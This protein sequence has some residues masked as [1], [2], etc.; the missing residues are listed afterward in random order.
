MKYIQQ[1][2]EFM[3]VMGQG[4]PETPTIP[5][6]GIRELRFNLIKEENHEL[7]EAAR[8]SDI[9]EV[10]DALCDL[11]YVVEGAFRAYGFSPELADELFDEVQRSNMSKTCA[12]EEEAKQSVE[13]LFIAQHQL[14]GESREKYEFDYKASGDRWVVF[15]T[16]DNKV[17]K[18]IN[19]SEPNLRPILERHGVR[20]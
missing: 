17:L 9:I 5:T 16:S 1:V 20:C 10:A 8:N 2:S 11:R 4:M 3:T 14:E 13:A 12:T 6:E 15:R 18:G 19:Y 7:V